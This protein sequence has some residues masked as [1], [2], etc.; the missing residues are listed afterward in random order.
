MEIGNICL[1]CGNFGSTVS[2]TDA[3]AILD[4]FTSAGGNFVDTANVY[5][6]WNPDSKNISEQFIGEW[7][8]TR[9]AYD[10]LV[11][12]TKGGHYDLKIPNV[13]RINKREIRKDL[14]ESLRT[15]GL[16][17]I[18]FYWLHRDNESVQIEE[19]IDIMEELVREEKIRYYGASNYKLDRLKAAAAYA[20]LK[21]CKGFSAVSNQWSL[22][23]ATPAPRMDTGAAEDLTLFAMNAE[24][25]QWHKNTML[26]VIP[27]SASA[28]GFFNK[29][30]LQHPVVTEGKLKTPESELD[31]PENI[32]A[33]YLNQHN[34][35]VYEKL[36][37]L[38]NKYN[39]SLHTL[40]IAYL[41]NQPFQ[42]IPVSSVRNTN[43]LNELTLAGD[44][45]LDSKELSEINRM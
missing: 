39:C 34:L 27:Y 42:T 19:I 7:L 12:A 20:R 9:N 14:E 21:G 43:Q 40:S 10:K 32:K 38:K 17:R 3:F 24:Y 35:R 8:R 37:N 29:L 6:K 23:V 15:L 16:D 13:S 31:L 11:V 5:G 30:Y 41:L 33:T 18:E 4:A 28:H 45:I 2:K 36:L 25:Y 26:P 44:I 1:G 22:A